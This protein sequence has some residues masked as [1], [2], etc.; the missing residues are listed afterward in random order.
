MKAFKIL[1]PFLLIVSLMFIISAC[2]SKGDA[3]T[4]NNKTNTYDE[5]RLDSTIKSPEISGLK[6]YNFE[7][8]LDNWHLSNWETENDGEH[9]FTS[10]ALSSDQKASGSSSVAI[11]CDMKGSN[12]K[13]KTTKGSFKLNFD[14]P[15][16]LRGKLISAKVYLPKSLF[17]KKFKSASFGT[18]LYIKTTDS[19]KWS[20]GGWNDIANTLQP[21][22]N[23]LSYAPIGVQEDDT[24]EIGIML[25][26]GN[27]APDWSGTIYIDDISY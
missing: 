23:K 9:G 19:Y 22:W 26:K 20:D 25:G 8:A 4:P 2:A 1:L 11:N 16:D 21:G 18:M 7:N 14:K 13:S 12:G 10:L 24:R 3:S 15:I 6:V 5:K 17:N 27:D